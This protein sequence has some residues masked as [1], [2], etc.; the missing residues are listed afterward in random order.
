MELTRLLGF[1]VGVGSALKRVGFWSREYGVASA[2]TR[3][4]SHT[5]AAGRVTVKPADS[6]KTFLIDSYKHLMEANPV[7]LFVHYNNLLKNEDQHYRSLVKQ[8]GGKLTMLRNGVF[9]AYLKNSHAAD[10]CGPI[11]RKERNRNHPLLP[12]F[13]GPTAAI[14]FPETSPASVAKILKVLEKAQDKLFVVGAKVEAEVYDVASLNQFKTLPGKTELQ[15]QL[16]GL[17]NVLGGAGLVRTLEA[18]SQTLYLTLSSHHESRSSKT[19]KE[20]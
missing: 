16:V 1:R 9:G 14:S 4:Q 2:K 15:A 6:R 3:L 20:E 19:G 18:G 12:L 11:S 17:L 8:N 13:K 10:P 7:V 5:D